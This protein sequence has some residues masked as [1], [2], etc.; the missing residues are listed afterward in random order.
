ML[1]NDEFN[2]RIFNLEERR[3]IALDRRKDIKTLYCVK[4]TQIK[5]SK[6]SINE[7]AKVKVILDGSEERFYRSKYINYNTIQLNIIRKRNFKVYYCTNRYTIKELRELEL[8]Q[9]LS[10][11]H[12]IKRSTRKA[13][14]MFLK[15]YVIVDES[16]LVEMIDII[17]DTR[18]QKYKKMIILERFKEENSLMIGSVFNDLE[19]LSQL[20]IRRIKEMDEY[21]KKLKC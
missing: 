3:E 15:S 20:E 5:L 13:F 19:A 11:Y 10:H 8:N 6:I 1:T 4:K 7:K 21:N 14:I 2:E 18:Q 16:L 12:E 17:S 9:M